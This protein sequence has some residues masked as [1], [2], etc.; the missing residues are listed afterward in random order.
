M[1]LQY[2]SLLGQ[3][4]LNSSNIGGEKVAITVDSSGWSDT[5]TYY[6]GTDPEVDDNYYP[7][8][9]TWFQRTWWVDAN[10]AKKY[11]N[12]TGIRQRITK[13][14]FLAC[15]GHSGGKQ[16]GGSDSGPSYFGPSE[17]YGCTFA[18]D[19]YIVGSDHVAAA[20]SNTLQD[21]DTFNCYYGGYNQTTTE[22]D[23]TSFGA[24]NLFGPGTGYEFDSQGHKRYRHEQIFKFTDAPYIEPGGSMFVHVRPTA[25]NPNSND[26][27]SLL[28]L[29]SNAPFFASEFEEGSSKYI[30][31]FN[32]TAWERILPAWRFNGTTWEVLEK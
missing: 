27:N 16:Y 26:N 15:P 1:N 3:N 20:S 29:Q 14:S 22:N 5:L 9:G 32:G 17:G 30:W 12:N 23:Q 11:V 8:R 4:R 6:L 24:V 28:V 31:R 7:L 18:A 21:I 13:M 19:I 10:W 25:W 2:G